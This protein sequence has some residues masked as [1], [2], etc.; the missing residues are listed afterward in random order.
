MIQT[1]SNYALVEHEQIIKLASGNKVNAKSES[2]TVQG[3]VR[4]PTSYLPA[5]FHHVFKCMID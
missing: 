5:Q 1:A 2:V 4:D 3:K